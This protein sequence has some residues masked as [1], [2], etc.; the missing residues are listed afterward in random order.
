[1]IDIPRW[2]NASEL[3]DRNLEAGRSG[4]VAVRCGGEEV[5]YGELARRMN[6][7]GSVLGELGVRQEDRVLMVLNDTPAFPVV[8]FGAMRMGAVPIPVNTLLGAEDYRF[9]VEDSRAR[10]VVVDET[11]YGKVWEGLEGYGEPVEVIVANGDVEGRKTLDE[12]L[13]GGEDELSPARTHRDDPAFWLYSSGSTGRPKG[14]VHLQHDILY[15]C[16]TYA[17]EVLKVTEEDVTFSASKLFHAYGLGGGLTFAVWAGAS[18][19]LYPGKPKPDA[20]LETIERFRPTL[21]FTVPTLYNAM[22]NHPGAERYDL[23]SIRL[24]ASA[25]EAL[26]P[27]IWRRWKETFGSVILDGI[28]STEMLH[29]FLSNTPEKL[30]PGSSGVPVPGYEV[31]ILDEEERPVEPGGAGYLYVKGDSAAAYYWRNHEKTKKTMKGEWLFA[32]DWYRQ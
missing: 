18:T 28:G 13:E 17:K 24:C 5:T 19:V 16:E 3:I 12:L 7:F 31:K 9:F 4:K 6:R 10:V 23:S 11:L 25:A 26:P 30:K 32:G 8:F 14:A 2:Y 21:F 29:I 27:A 20:V 1:M 22:L 15:T